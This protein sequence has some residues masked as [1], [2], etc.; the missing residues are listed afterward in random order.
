MV[1]VLQHPSTREG[2]V[3]QA[4]FNGETN[5]LPTGI[6]GY[7]QSM[8]T[9]RGLQIA[10]GSQHAVPKLVLVS[11]NYD[12]FWHRRTWIVNFETGLFYPQSVVP[13]MSM[14]PD[15]PISWIDN[16]II[17]SIPGCLFPTSELQ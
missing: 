14:Y 13:A 7:K 5:K 1:D 11:D 16:S 9:T 6:D 12:A 4:M 8:R 17:R 10:R 3:L 2:G 15:I